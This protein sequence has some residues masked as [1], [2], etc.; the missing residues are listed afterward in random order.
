M[1]KMND[2]IASCK[3]HIALLLAVALMFGA[4]LPGATANA[5]EEEYQ[6][7]LEIVLERFEDFEEITTVIHLE[8]VPELEQAI[9][10][11][12]ENNRIDV[13]TELSNLN[14][15]E[16]RLL[17]HDD[18]HFIITIPILNENY[19]M[20]SNLTVIYD[21]DFDI[22]DYTETHF[23]ESE[24]GFFKVIHYIDGV[25]VAETETEFEFID[26]AEFERQL[27]EFEA[28][29]YNPRARGIWSCLKAV[30]GISVV[31][32][33][34]VLA[35]CAVSCAINRHSCGNCLST[36]GVVSQGTIIGVATC[37]GA[38]R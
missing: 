29:F 37:F 15:A 8:D 24:N 19:N 32:A 4:L 18:G 36:L 35:V 3:K 28:L 23:Q 12:F 9:L 22:L 6:S 21:G 11:D 34:L 26:N 7:D 20:L 25:L 13:Q 17:E 38:R 31:I 16:K 30:V 5:Q 2:Y 1:E 27:Q 33:A 10:A 14:F